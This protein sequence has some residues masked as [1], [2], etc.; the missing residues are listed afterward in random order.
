[1]ILFF[2]I[3]KGSPLFILINTGN[4]AAHVVR[5]PL[6]RHSLHLCFPQHHAGFSSWA[7]TS[8]HPP[9][10]LG[11]FSLWKKANQEA[12][13]AHHLFRSVILSLPLIWLAA[14][15]RIRVRGSW[16]TKY[17]V[18]VI[19]WILRASHLDCY[20]LSL[21]WLRAASKVEEP[22]SC[23]RSSI[24]RLWTMQDYR[25]WSTRDMC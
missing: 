10:C 18:Y 13:V 23:N 22:A 19:F 24:G 4:S 8:R 9:A 12:V 25:P 6:R 17:W 15:N 3:G 14:G 1:M 11:G 20:H 21:L 2:L 16:T 5:P 7:L